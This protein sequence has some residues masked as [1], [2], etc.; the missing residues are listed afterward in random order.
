MNSI[1]YSI[2]L[3]F[4]IN[5]RLLAQVPSPLDR[6]ISVD[7]RNATVDNALR[8]ISRA[9]QFEFSYNASRIDVNAV[10]TVRATNTPVR[11]VLNRVFRNRVTFKSRGNHVILVQAEPA[12]AEPKNFL[13][14]GY[15]LDEQTGERIGRASVFE[16]TTL[17]STVSNPF[18][19]YRLQL[20]TNLPTVRLDV[21][22]Q[23]YQGETVVVRSRISHSVTIRMTPQPPVTSTVQT[24]PIRVTEDTLRSVA[25]SLSSVP[26]EMP[27]PTIDSIP[28]QPVSVVD[29]GLAS[30][31]KLFVSAQQAIHD[32]NLSRDTLYRDW[33]VSFLPFIGTNH[34]LSGRI[35]NRLSFNALVGY[36]FS[37]RTLEVGGLANLVRA[38]VHGFQAAGLA[39]VVGGNVQAVQVGG[40]AN[41]TDQN[42]T[43]VQVAGLANSV[44]KSVDGLQ[45]AG[46]ANYTN[47]DVRGMQ[48]GGLVNVAAQSIRGMQLAGLANY[49]HNDVKGWQISGILN[50]A[51]RVTSGHQ[52][53]LFNVAD[54][55]GSAPIGLLSYIR[56]GGYQRVEVAANEVNMLNVTFR[57]GVRHF[58]N[59]LTAGHSFG[60]DGSPRLSAG[61]G[62]GSASRLSRATLFNLEA[63]Y[64]HLFYF[65]GNYSGEWNNHIRLNTLLETKLSGRLSLAFGPSFNWYFSNDGRPR[66][67]LQPDVTLFADR[68]DSYSNTLHSGWIGF[69]VG[70]RYGRW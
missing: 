35:S 21:R 27:T 13:L 56:K 39:N 69:Q 30:I 43:G 33:Q 55:V 26:V 67:L 23:A 68:T 19:Y 5:I 34:R 4:F 53:G 9:G 17:A 47:E 29:Q 51:R 38:D 58:Y 15:I 1:R 8:Q 6:L 16:K 24:L 14:D 48:I 37:V 10:V 31:S 20:P 66:P 45:L 40:L 41:Y 42:V 12:E 49:T 54:T 7:I 65:D 57:T 44:G 11:E 32:I 3:L 63:I 62:I 70:L 25:S 28:P 59:I 60:R 36:S 61:Y 52:I 18:G 22:K 50:R 64:H 46:M 2:F